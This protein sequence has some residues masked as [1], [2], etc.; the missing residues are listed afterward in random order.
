MRK[1]II[2]AQNTFK[3]LLRNRVLY[4]FLFFAIFLLL[5]MVALGQLSYT[6]QLRLTLS[7]GLASIHICLVG[8]TIFIGGSVVYREIEKLTIL[9]LLARSISRTE[10]LLGKYLGFLKLMLLFIF[11]FYLLYYGNMLLMGFEVSGVDLLLV[12]AGFA[13][14]I[15]VLLAVT[16]FFSTFCASFLTIIFSLCFFIIGHWAVNLTTMVAENPNNK[17]YM[18][19]AKIVQVVLPNLE[20]YNWRLYPLEHQLTPHFLLV[21]LITTVCWVVFFLMSASFIFRNK[22]FA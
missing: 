9:T 16:I 3:E 4:A 11:G 17:T 15:T 18:A 12:F 10:F 14:E 19:V 7:L 8:L 6:E 20:N 22:D 13:L 21:T 5:L 1:T 2:I